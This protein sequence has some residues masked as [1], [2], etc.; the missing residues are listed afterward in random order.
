MGQKRGD[1]RMGSDHLLG[2]EKLMDLAELTGKA[3]YAAFDN[4]ALWK[5]DLAV[6]FGLCV[7]TGEWHG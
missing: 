2:L 6:R 1:V 4:L 5:R 3:D 7:G